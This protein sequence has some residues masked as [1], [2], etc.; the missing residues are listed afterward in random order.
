MHT[1]HL[2][3]LFIHVAPFF[4]FFFLFT[5]R[6]IVSLTREYTFWDQD[7]AMIFPLSACHLKQD[8]TGTYV[9]MFLPTLLFTCF[10]PSAN[11]RI[12]GFTRRAAECVGLA[13]RLRHVNG[14]ARLIN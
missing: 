12:V 6:H 1:T 10:C 13:I 5:I 14:G 11:A 9:L 4:F 2:C 8:C 3:F 7:L